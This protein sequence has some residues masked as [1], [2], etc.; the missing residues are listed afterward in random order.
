METRQHYL[1]RMISEISE[2]MRG[3]LPNIERAC[4]HEERKEMRVELA[5]LTNEAS[6]E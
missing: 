5:R 2:I 4:L 3:P 6:H 1:R